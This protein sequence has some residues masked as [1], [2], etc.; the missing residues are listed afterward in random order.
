MRTSILVRNALTKLAVCAHCPPG[1][2][3]RSPLERVEN[4][5]PLHQPFGI[6]AG[7]PGPAPGQNLREF[8]GF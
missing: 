7:H 3:L 1:V 5:E 4:E 2:P 8:E 6:I